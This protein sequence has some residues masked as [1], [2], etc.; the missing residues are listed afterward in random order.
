MR[1]LLA[2][3][4][5]LLAGCATAPAVQYV[6]YEVK[7]PVEVPCT[8]QPVAKP[9]WATEKLRKADTGDAKVKALLAEREERKGYE[10]KL[11]KS[12]EGCR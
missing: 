8:A 1:I 10:E 5:A 11:E 4:L 12:T 6:P 9:P 3:A 7:V 2:F